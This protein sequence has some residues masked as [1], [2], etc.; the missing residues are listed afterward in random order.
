MSLSHKLTRKDEK[1]LSTWPAAHRHKGVLTR[2]ETHGLLMTVV[3][4]PMMIPPSV[5]LPETYSY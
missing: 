5:W 2:L 3:C 4:C 1:K